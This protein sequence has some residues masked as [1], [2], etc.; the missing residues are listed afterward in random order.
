MK[1]ESCLFKVA[2]KPD[3]LDMIPDGFIEFGKWQG[4]YVALDYIKPGDSVV[5]FRHPFTELLELKVM[6]NSDAAYYANG[7]D[8]LDA[9]VSRNIAQKLGLDQAGDVIY[10]IKKWEDKHV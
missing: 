9:T 2:V 4:Q 8:C 6:V 5:V 1:V 7:P 3:D 10:V